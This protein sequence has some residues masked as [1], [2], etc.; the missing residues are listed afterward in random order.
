MVF[1]IFLNIQDEEFE[2][3]RKSHQLFDENYIRYLQTPISL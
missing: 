3:F 1:Y 2:S